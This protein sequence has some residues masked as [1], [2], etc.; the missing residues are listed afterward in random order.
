MGNKAFTSGQWPFALVELFPELG[1]LG[2]FQEVQAKL[3]TLLLG[4]R[5]MV[6]APDGVDFDKLSALC[7]ATTTAQPTIFVAL[8]AF[9]GHGVS[10]W[11]H[12]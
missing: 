10:I 8:G 5:P 1:C 12:E 6:V 9:S 11:I 2:G 7:L 3:L 4:K